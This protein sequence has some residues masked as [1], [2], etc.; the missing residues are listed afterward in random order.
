LRSPMHEFAHGLSHGFRKLGVCA[1]RCGKFLK[2]P[3]PHG[4]SFHNGSSRRSGLTYGQDFTVL[5]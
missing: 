3:A 5:I 4:I 2:V 1:Y